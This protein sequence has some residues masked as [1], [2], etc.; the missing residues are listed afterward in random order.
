MKAIARMTDRSIGI[1][2][3]KIYNVYS[4][5]KD[6]T[7]YCTTD[8]DGCPCS[9]DKNRFI[10]IGDEESMCDKIL[11]L[12]ELFDE[13]AR[14]STERYERVKKERDQYRE[15]ARDALETVSMLMNAVDRNRIP[16][17]KLMEIDYIVDNILKVFHTL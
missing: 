12:S 16:L 7:R 6:N 14:T 13:Y 2:Y 17:S 4:M 10:L 8:D 1:T 9:M 11:K 15:I 5:Y 3:G